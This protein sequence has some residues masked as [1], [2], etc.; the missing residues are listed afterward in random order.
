MKEV[1]Q[2]CADKIE[3]TISTTRHWSNITGYLYHYYEFYQ[4]NYQPF[5]KRYEYIRI[6]NDYQDVVDAIRDRSIDIL[7]I[8]DAGD[9]DGEHYPEACEALIEAF[10]ERFPNESRFEV[11]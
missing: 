5:E 10:E 2:K 3:S 1:G 9:L 11:F 4:G 7:C 8:N 6:G